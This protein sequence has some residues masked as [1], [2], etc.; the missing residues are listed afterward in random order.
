[1]LLF[2][3]DVTTEDPQ[4]ALATLRNELGRVVT[5]PARKAVHWSLLSKADLLPAGRGRGARRGAR[6]HGHLGRDRSEGLSALKDA[7]RRDA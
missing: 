6:R 4:A 1:M 2:L 5:G 7:D 3:V